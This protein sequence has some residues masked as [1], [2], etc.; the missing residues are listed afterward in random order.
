MRMRRKLIECASSPFSSPEPVVSWSRGPLEIKPTGS[1]D[2]M[3]SS[4]GI[5]FI[6]S[7]SRRKSD[8]GFR[9]RSRKPCFNGQFKDI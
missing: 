4:Q 3:A 5:S 9:E 8:A 6:L 7:T 1:G 2:E